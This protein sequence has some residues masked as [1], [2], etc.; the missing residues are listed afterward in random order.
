VG[1]N[2]AFQPQATYLFPIWHQLL[3][4]LLNSKYLQ[5]LCLKI[6]SE[7]TMESPNWI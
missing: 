4:V 5:M 7:T 3:N 2:E 1:Y 6:G